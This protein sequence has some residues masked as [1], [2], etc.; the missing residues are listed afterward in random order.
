MGQIVAVVVI[1]LMIITVFV[2]MAYFEHN[3]FQTQDIKQ[4]LNLSAKVLVNSVE[5]AQENFN[6]IQ[7]G[8]NN[9]DISDIE[10]DK[11]SLLRN[12]Y[13]NIEANYVDK[14][15]LEQIKRSILVKALVLNDKFYIA[16]QDDIWSAPYFFTEKISGGLVYLSAKDDRVYYYNGGVKEFG[17]LSDFAISEEQKNDIIINKVNRIIAQYTY[18]ERVRDNGLSIQFNNPASENGEYRHKQAGFSILSGGTT[19]FVVYGEN[20]EFSISDQDMKYKNY[21]VVGYTLQ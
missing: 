8:F 4:N 7:A 6:V 18:E 15:K 12:F 16:G 2:P 9:I 1:L 13:A 5:Q 3:E 11:A 21:N 14:E 10:I 17:K 20:K 19:F